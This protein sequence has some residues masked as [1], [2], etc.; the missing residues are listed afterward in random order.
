MQHEKN[1]QTMSKVY[2]VLCEFKGVLLPKRMEDNPMF[3]K[4]CGIDEL[5]YYGPHHDTENLR[6]DMRAIGNDIRTSINKA[7]RRMTHG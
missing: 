3:I 5:T 4:P 2:T 1:S 7:K 6:S